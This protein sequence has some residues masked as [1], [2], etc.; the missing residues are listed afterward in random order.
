M[1]KLD[2]A[3]VND[4]WTFGLMAWDDEGEVFDCGF[5][6]SLEFEWVFGSNLMA[7]LSI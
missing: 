7:G 3:V 5:T 4:G 2:G 6:Q 1:A